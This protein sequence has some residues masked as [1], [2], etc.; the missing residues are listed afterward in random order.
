MEN[1]PNT[2]TKINFLIMG[3]LSALFFAPVFAADDG[4][5]E[6]VVKGN[7]L[8][9]DQVSALKT[10]VAVLNVPQTVSIITD[11]DIRKQGFR[12]IGDIIRYTPG[13]NTSQGEGHRDSVVFRGVRSTADFFQDGVRDDVQYYRSLYNVEQVEILRGPNAL[14]FGRGGTGGALNRVTKKA[15]LG[16]TFGAVDFGVDDFGANDI[17]LDYNTSSGA[18]SAFR[19][20]IHSDALENHRDFYDGDRLGI[21]PTIKIKVS[22]RTTVDLSYEH[23]DHERYIDRGIPTENGKPVERFS[24]ITFG[25]SRGDN[26]TTLEADIFR[27]IVSTNFSDATKANLTIVSSEFEKM[28][29]NYYASGYSAGASVVT[30]DGYNDPTE[31]ENTIISGNLINELEIGS[32]THTLLFGA[33][34]IDTTNKNKR[35]DTYWATTKSDKETFN[36][37]RPMNFLVNSV[38]VT[39]NNDFTEDLNR[40]TQSDIEVTSIFFQDQIDVSDKLKLLIGGRHD[41]FDITVKDIKNGSA[42]SREDKEFSPRAGIIFKPRE[43]V[44]LYYSYSES[45]LP[46]SG[47]QF[48][49]LSAS[50]AALDPDVFESSE[51]GAKVEIT[52]DLGFT[53]AYFDSEQVRAVKDSVS[54]ETSEIVGLQVDGFELEVKGDIN[55]KMS[56]VFGYSALDGK[57]SKGGEPREIPD[58]M[59]SLFATYEVSD[60]FGWAVGITQQ[61]E[62]NIA[63]DKPGLVLPE[64]TRVDLGAYYQ[65]ADDLSVQMN[66][67]NLTDELYFP[68]SHS[69]HQASVGEPL[70]VR[71]S[72]RMTF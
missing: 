8:Y 6:I 38:G 53:I 10:P 55:D 49:S 5:E 64:Y 58:Q 18:D 11:E 21:N 62:S 28:Y 43:N 17:A 12:Q 7:V 65:I 71:L 48:K 66:L 50:S 61:G 42:Q 52:D 45:F 46:R 47:E 15:V 30:V 68:H 35:Y 33:E 3:L 27:A 37:T 54:G 31:R 36:I 2:Q 13:V 25:D 40:Q 69:T 19:L 34:M 22:D 20:M 72:I 70:N 4:I 51:I 63:N 29:Q 23:A 67:E 59:L 1:W 57:T 14:L 26:L 41:S 60:K 16:D 56:L 39:T 9:A 24:K 32:T 44:S